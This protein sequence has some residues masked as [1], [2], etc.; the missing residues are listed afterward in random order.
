[1]IEI[2]YAVWIASVALFLMFSKPRIKGDI[3]IIIPL[4]IMALITL[5]LS[6]K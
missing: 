2:F 5:L 4:F 6:F 1:M 3:F